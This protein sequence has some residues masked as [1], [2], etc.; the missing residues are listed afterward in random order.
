MTSPNLPSEIKTQVVPYPPL[1]A[2][3]MGKIQDERR[4]QVLAP[5][6]VVHLVSCL[7]RSVLRQDRGQVGLKDARNLSHYSKRLFSNSEIDSEFLNS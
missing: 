5:A 1:G 3:E 7:F 4:P 6:V 2:N